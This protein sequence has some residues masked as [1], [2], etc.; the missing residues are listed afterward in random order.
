MSIPVTILSG[1]LGAGKTTLLNAI[2]REDH[3][4]RIGVLVNDFGDINIDAQLIEAVDEDVVQLS[5]G[6]ICC[7]IREDLLSVLWKLLEQPNPPDYLII[8][9]SGVADPAAIA[10]TFSTPGIRETA[11]LD[12]VV[13]LVDCAQALAGHPKDVQQLM[14][15]Q[16]LSSQI[17]VLNKRDLVDE[18]AFQRVQAWVTELAPKATQLEAINGNVPVQFLLDVQHNPSIN[19][20]QAVKPAFKSWSLTTDKPLGSLRSINH[21]LSQ[22]PAEIVRVKGVLYLEE[23]PAQQIIVHRVGKRTD[24]YPGKPWGNAKPITELVAIGVPGGDLPDDM[25]IW[26]Q[27]KV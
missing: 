23:M 22:L 17:V 11:R 15:D 8:E 6:C 24:V 7:T 18:N 9:A 25:A 14:S 5:N 13:T 16:L 3:G 12:A 10:F 27:S 21:V 20:R 4:L 2:L 19:K 1:F 26:F